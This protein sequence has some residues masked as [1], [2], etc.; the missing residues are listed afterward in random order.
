MAKHR[1]SFAV[2]MRTVSQ[3][4]QV[5]FDDLLMAGE[6]RSAKSAPKAKTSPLSPTS[7]NEPPQESKSQRSMSKPT[8]PS[9]TH[10]APPLPAK[11]PVSMP[12][13]KDGDSNSNSGSAGSS[14]RAQRKGSY[15]TGTKKSRAGKQIQNLQVGID[16]A[17]LLRQDS[18]ST[19]VKSASIAKRY[20]QK[21]KKS[22]VSITKKTKVENNKKSTALPKRQ[23]SSVV[24]LRN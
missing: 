20:K 18:L 15:K 21:G 10:L 5:S 2:P 1:P 12:V 9:T 14:P 11:R 6:D 22:R 16:G 23:I 3:P 19:V 8:G 4:M 17:H 13:P 7:I 24:P